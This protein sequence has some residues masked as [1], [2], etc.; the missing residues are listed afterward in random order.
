MAPGERRGHLAIMPNFSMSCGAAFRVC[1]IIH[2]DR[3][4]R[5]VL[6]SVIPHD[7]FDPL[8]IAGFN[9]LRMEV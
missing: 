3:V 4:S 5:L 6:D 1:A 9:W 2:P 7:T 8:E